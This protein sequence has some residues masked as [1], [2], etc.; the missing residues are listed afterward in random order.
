[1]I[2]RSDLAP[3]T[4]CAQAI[5]AAI[6]YG[7]KNPEMLKEW[8][9]ISNHVGILAAKNE[10]DLVE[11]IGRLKKKGIDYAEFREPDLG[12]C[13]T[14]VALE[15]TEKSRKAVSSFPLA[16]KVPACQ[17]TFDRESSIRRLVI[18]MDDCPQ[19]ETQSVL[20]H[21]LSVRNYALELYDYIY[22]DGKLTKQWR[23][24]EWLEHY[25]EEF[26][27][28]LLDRL[29]I[30][31]YTVFHDCGKPFCLEYDKDGRKHFPNH[32]KI[33]ERTYREV[34]SNN[35][36]ASLIGMD[37]DIHLLKSDGLKEFAKRKEAL[38]LLLV[39]L[40]EIHS[41]AEMFGGIDSTSF[42]IKWK[43]IDK[44]GKQILKEKFG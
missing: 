11:L 14:A 3:G 38:T 28:Q 2:T 8:H 4:Q 7:L 24:P 23:I 42:K 20:D 25:R 29:T 37:M 26:Q 18:K 34:F 15:P 40:A 9:D 6:D 39:G 32:A 43:Q 30:E 35:Q 41:N 36:V 22:F 13:I 17:E 33:S 5:H 16:M 1:M 27:T 19:T 21:G 31:H 12:D 10:R 44:R